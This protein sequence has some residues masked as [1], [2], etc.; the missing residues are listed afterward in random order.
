M[1]TFNLDDTAENQ[2]WTKARKFDL[3]LGDRQFLEF[4]LGLSSN[5]VQRQQRL[6][7]LAQL[8][9]ANDA[10]PKWLLTELEAAMRTAMLKGDYVGHPFR[11]NQWMDASGVGRGGAG[12]SPDQDRQ[13]YEMRQ[14]GQTWEAIA[15]TL[16]YA[17]GGAV[18]RLAMRHEDR[19]RTEGVRADPV[20]PPP[21]PPT[22]QTSPQTRY[23][24]G[25]PPA[26]TDQN[27]AAQEG[28]PLAGWVEF[29]PEIQARLDARDRWSERNAQF[30]AEAVAIRDEAIKTMDEADSK[31]VL[32][33]DG[34][35][36][37]RWA[38]ERDAA[39]AQR[40][41][42]HRAEL[43]SI[44]VNELVVDMRDE[45]IVA[46]GFRPRSESEKA[47]L[48]AAVNLLDDYSESALRRTEERA[49]AKEL[50]AGEQLSL[51]YFKEGREGKGGRMR[52][53]EV[54]QQVRAR[55]YGAE[56]AA[57]AEFERQLL[58]KY[59]IK[60]LIAQGYT[61]QQIGEIYETAYGVAADRT[62]T[63]TFLAV[64]RGGSLT[65]AEILP[66]QL[67]AVAEIEGPL[68]TSNITIT[69]PPRVLAQVLNDG[70]YKTQFETRRS[71]GLNDPQARSSEEAERFGYPPHMKP[72]FRPVYGMVE[73]GGVQAPSERNNLQYGSAVVVLKSE[74]RERTTFTVGDSLSLVR[75]SAPVMNPRAQPAVVGI[76]KGSIRSEVYAWENPS[77]LYLEAQIH[78][79]VRTSDIAS[80]IFQV[81]AEIV[82]TGTR[83]EGR[84]I[85]RT[86]PPSRSVLTALDKAGIAYQIITKPEDIVQPVT[87][88]AKRG[89]LPWV[90]LK[91]DFVGHPFRGNQWTDGAGVSRVG[92]SSVPTD[93]ARGM[94]NRQVLTVAA[95]LMDKMDIVAAAGAVIKI[96]EPSREAREVYN[97]QLEQKQL[98]ETDRPV[99]RLPIINGI[100]TTEQA[101]NDEGTVVVIT[102]AND[103]ILGALSMQKVPT[104]FT[105]LDEAK[106]YHPM[107]E[108]A[109]PNQKYILMDAMGSTGRQDGVGSTL[110]GQAVLNAARKGAGLYLTPLNKT[111]EQYWSSIGFETVDEGQEFLKYQYLDPDTVKSIAD[112]I[113]DPMETQ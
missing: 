13:A 20:T 40:L 15:A 36:L 41:E 109:Q 19:L 24:N 63:P 21:E 14:A 27:V 50:L 101:L 5:P 30:E 16:G 66:Q 106:D 70:R 3:P 28:R 61:Q 110:F 18:R 23:V 104:T 99:Q 44:D 80:V 46:A 86:K 90:M 58:V 72:E 69:M 32:R 39:F 7:Q 75:P 78:G 38:A 48:R 81:D 88:L 57:K 33:M 98:A 6:I 56:D 35:Y 42:K 60:G 26:S 71:G 47:E 83:D 65:A 105:P 53:D 96:G 2:D 108:V 11:G 17:N 100:L 103:Q 9:I 10:A 55:R 73:L 82:G 25:L 94:T 52:S 34:Q 77:K 45:L 107:M 68:K 62:Y 95:N 67:E 102:D 43:P 54:N 87:K 111:A 113:D 79:G 49:A 37:V 12:S 85:G 1:A 112:N 59:D 8:P 91:G 76:D 89:F 74:T 93:P 22:P 29:S 97:A 4:Q 84:I 51:F 64:T 92:A 31:S